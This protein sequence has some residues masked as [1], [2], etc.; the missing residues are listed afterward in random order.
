MRADTVA[1]LRPPFS[2]PGKMAGWFFLLLSLITVLGCP[3]SNTHMVPMRDGVELAA[4]VYLPPDSSG[5]W[6]VL[7]IRTPY[8]REE[9]TSLLGYT[10]DYAL[11]VQDVRGQFDSEGE[12]RPFYDDGWGELQDGYDTA[13]WITDQEWCNGKIGTFGGSALG[14]T[15]HLLAG[16]SP[17]GVVCQFI[18]IASDNLY[19]QLF[20]QG[21]AFR[22]NL[23]T[24]WL[25]DR[26]ASY[27]IETIK[28][29]PDYDTFWASVNT[30][31]R[32]EMIDLPA[33]HIGGWY[34]IALKGTINGFL[35]RQMDGAEGA[36]GKQKLLIGPWTHNGIFTRRQG[37]A[38]Y[39]ANAALDEEALLSQWIDYW[40]KGDDTG[41]MDE[42]PVRYY[43]M[44]DLLDPEAPGN[45]W[46]DATTWP[47]Y[48]LSPQ[49]YYMHQGGML[50]SRLPEEEDASSTYLFDPE[51]PVPTLGGANLFLD[52][53]PFIQ[54][55][56]EDRED[57]ILFSTPPLEAPLEVTGDLK[58]ILYASSDTVDTDFTA[59]LTDVYPATDDYPYERSLLVADGIIR[60]RYR[61]SLTTPALMT[62]GTI[63]R[64]EIDLWATSIIFNKGH[65][66]RLALSSSNYPRFDVNT[67]TGGEFYDKE[68]VVK[69]T[70]TI[71][72]NTIYPSHTSVTRRTI[73]EHPCRKAWVSEQ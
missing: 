3:S 29:H 36:R 32:I 23:I 73:E 52:A 13:L 7:L 42:P 48:D 63:Y 70:N 19:P 6:P 26:G 62:P 51:D 28:E 37:E 60:A 30:E 4:D 39:P 46:Q 8:G 59:K 16:T 14:I 33:Y 56:L 49:P 44:G 38:E 1:V 47:P 22:L 57:V 15:Q 55:P 5:P 50:S 67:N 71:Y 9:D 18:L 64:F 25:R 61:N 17:P 12:Y 31:T 69:A 21:G 10:N 34:D 65:R 41:I 58:V 66:I 11:V 53:G 68:E 40:L 35:T 43:V 24:T 45:V 27:W 54:T 2:R 72:H 20:F